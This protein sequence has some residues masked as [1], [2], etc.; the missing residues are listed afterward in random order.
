ML[1]PSQRRCLPRRIRLKNERLATLSAFRGGR[2][3]GRRSSPPFPRLSGDSGCV[4]TAAAP[5]SLCRAS[6]T[7][8]APPIGDHVSGGFTCSQV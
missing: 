5:A 1:I 8:L 6:G 3:S 7:G 4:V 2:G